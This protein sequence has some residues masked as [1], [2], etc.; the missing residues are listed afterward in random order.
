M[1]IWSTYHIILVFKVYDAVVLVCIRVWATITTVNVR[2]FSWLNEETCVLNLLFLKL[3]ISPHSKKHIDLLSNSVDLTV[4]E[5]L[6]ERDY[7]PCTLYCTYNAFKIHSYQYFITLNDWTIFHCTL[8]RIL[9][10]DS[11]VD[12][13]F[14]YC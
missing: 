3:S 7:I 5:I 6:Y 14:D 11:S 10:K 4:L 13:F 1:K 12:G 9:F 2:P 8:Y